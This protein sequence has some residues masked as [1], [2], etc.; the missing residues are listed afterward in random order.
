[1]AS[2]STSSFIFLLSALLFGTGGIIIQF[3]SRLIVHVNLYSNGRVI[4]LLAAVTKQWKSNFL[5][6]VVSKLVNSLA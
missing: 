6:A 1:M 5:I 4:L 2:R 3:I